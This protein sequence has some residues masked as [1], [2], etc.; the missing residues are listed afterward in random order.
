M[1]DILLTI[2]AIYIIYQFIRFIFDI[3][4]ELFLP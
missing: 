1:M 4:R 3:W 2:V